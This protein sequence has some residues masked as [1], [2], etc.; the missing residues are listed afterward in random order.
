MGWE[1]Q[2]IYSKIVI[3]LT[4]NKPKFNNGYQKKYSRMGISNGIMYMCNL[5]DI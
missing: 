5:S 1:Y 3:Y 2:I 4:Y